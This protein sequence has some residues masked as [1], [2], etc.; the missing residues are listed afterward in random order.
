MKTNYGNYND[1]DSDNDKKKTRRGKINFLWIT[2]RHNMNSNTW[3][4][5]FNGDCTQI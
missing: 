1:D 4:T 5:Q 2:G 3:I